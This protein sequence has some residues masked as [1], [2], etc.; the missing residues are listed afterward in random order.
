MRCEASSFS[1]RC[2]NERPSGSYADSPN[3]WPYVSS[4]L[5][6]S[7]LVPRLVGQEKRERVISLPRRYEV[8]SVSAKG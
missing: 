2:E 1:L 4:S 6:L 8:L 5:R 7:R 3:D